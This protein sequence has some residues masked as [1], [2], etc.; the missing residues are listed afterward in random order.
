MVAAGQGVKLCV[1]RFF[2][3]IEA[4]IIPGVFVF[5]PVQNTNLT[6]TTALWG[7]TPQVWTVA[8]FQF[9]V[10]ALLAVIYRYM[11][12]ILP[13]YE[14]LIALCAACSY[15]GV[16]CSF[17][18]VVL[19]GGSLDYIRLFDWFT[20]D[21]K[22]IYLSLAALTVCLILLL[23]YTLSYY[24]MTKGEKKEKGLWCWLKAGMPEKPN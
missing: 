11:L 23:A 18:D 17:I 7:V 1:T 5:A 22:D 21:L 14:K 20:F 9:V 12:Y 4:A 24:R 13:S 6:Y 16:I 15:S 19:W 8:A 10:L 2:M 3:D